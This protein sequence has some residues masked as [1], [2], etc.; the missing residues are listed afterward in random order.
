[1]ADEAPAAVLVA[2]PAVPAAAVAEPPAHAAPLPDAIAATGMAPGT[3]G[4][5]ADETA[6]RSP[7][8]VVSMTD[9]PGQAVAV[10][11]EG[12]IALTGDPDR[13]DRLPAGILTGIV[14][15]LL[16][17]VALMLIAAGNA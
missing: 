1:M 17:C 14:V 16:L 13:P 11:P 2:G 10:D 7:G 3:G 4:T 6:V 9:A 8:P 12:D 5:V 15:I